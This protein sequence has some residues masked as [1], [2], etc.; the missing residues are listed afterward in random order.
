MCILAFNQNQSA[1]VAITKD[2][3]RMQT[4]GT[5]DTVM[6][7]YMCIHPI[8]LLA[9]HSINVVLPRPKKVLALLL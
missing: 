2:S 5:R 7:L 4:L 6:S 9:T 8:H 3:G 1:F